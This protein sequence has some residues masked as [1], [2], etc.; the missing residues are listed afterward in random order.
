MSLNNQYLQPFIDHSSPPPP[1]NGW[2]FPRTSFAR[3]LQKNLASLRQVIHCQ[4]LIWPH[5]WLQDELKRFNDDREGEAFTL[6]DFWRTAI[7][8]LQMAGAFEKE[9]SLMVGATPEV[10]RKHYEKLDRMATAK[11]RVLSHLQ[12]D[13]SDKTADPTAPTFARLLRA[14]EKSALDGNENLPQTIGA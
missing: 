8:G 10:I 11:R 4:R 13:G 6:H 2:F 3:L 12:T 5:C 7:T 14:E 9:T 1:P